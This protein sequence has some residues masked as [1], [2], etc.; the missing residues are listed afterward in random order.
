[1]TVLV[2][3]Y[4]SVCLLVTMLVSVVVSDCVP[5][6]TDQFEGHNF[7]LHKDFLMM[8]LKKCRNMCADCVHISKVGLIT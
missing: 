3:H 7:N 5:H 1:V 6:I 2:S 8:A 4:A